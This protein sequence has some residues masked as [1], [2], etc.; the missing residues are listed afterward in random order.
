MD[1]MTRKTRKSAHLI[2][3]RYP[4]TIKV[5]A[6]KSALLLDSLKAPPAVKC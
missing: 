6:E 4:E 3:T 2:L 1:T 5:L